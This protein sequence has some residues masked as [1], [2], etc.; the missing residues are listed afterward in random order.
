MF[1][2]FFLCLRRAPDAR[3]PC[4]SL[5]AGECD[6]AY[7]EAAKRGARGPWRCH[8]VIKEGESDTPS[9]GFW[10]QNEP[11]NLASFWIAE[12]DAQATG[13]RVAGEGNKHQAISL[14][15]LEPMGRGGDAFAVGGRCDPRLSVRVEPVVS[16]VFSAR[17]PVTI[18]P[19]VMVS[20]RG[21][22]GSVTS[23]MVY[24][25]RLGGGEA[26]EADSKYLLLHGKE[27]VKGSWNGSTA[28]AGKGGG[29]EWLEEERNWAADFAKFE[30]AGDAVYVL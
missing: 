25:S 10:R 1:A 14:N 13:R 29:M 4:S 24:T 22:R 2:S 15:V 27:A 16:G 30:H 21:D 7:G 8:K 11:L 3:S 20:A 19:L 12:L 9:S 17:A 28:G 18:L 26:A 5:S 6:D 23:R